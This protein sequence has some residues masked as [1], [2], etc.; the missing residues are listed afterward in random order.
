MASGDSTVAEDSP[1]Q[2]K[3]KGLITVSA[4]N[5][6]REKKEKKSKGNKG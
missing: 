2:L 3:V 5:N 4:D 6:R 1:H